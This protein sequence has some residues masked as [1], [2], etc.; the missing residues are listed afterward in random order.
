MSTQS[1]R[2]NEGYLFNSDDWN[3]DIAIELANEEGVQNSG[4]EETARM[5]HGLVVL[6]NYPSRESQGA[7]SGSLLCG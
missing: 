5:E 3:W 7:M 2:D 1:S 6:K 4:D